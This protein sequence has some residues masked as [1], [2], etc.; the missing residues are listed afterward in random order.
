VQVV[1]NLCFDFIAKSITVNKRTLADI[2]ISLRL[3]DVDFEDIIPTNRLFFHFFDTVC[4]SHVKIS[5]LFDFNFLFV[6][7][8]HSICLWDNLF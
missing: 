6:G 1:K 2:G 3:R 4:N 7:G 8:T 5:L